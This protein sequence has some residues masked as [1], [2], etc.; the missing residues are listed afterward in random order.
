MRKAASG[1]PIE[2]GIHILVLLIPSVAKG[3]QRDLLG[4]A[5]KGEP[6]SIA[7]AA[8]RPYERNPGDL[9]GKR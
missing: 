2:A 9:N 8:G 4:G 7:K 6:A 3:E 1:G 5:G